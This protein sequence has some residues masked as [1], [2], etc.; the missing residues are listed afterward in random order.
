MTRTS[1]RGQ[2][3][4]STLAADPDL[5]KIIE[6]FIEEMPD[7]VLNLIDRLGACDWD[8]LRREVHRL[9]GAAGSHGFDSITRAAARVEEAFGR[10]DPGKEIHAALDALVALCGRARAGRR[11]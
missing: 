6:Q 5:E 8:G 3:L 7:R 2:P 11:G 4:Y 10:S 9:R 1:D